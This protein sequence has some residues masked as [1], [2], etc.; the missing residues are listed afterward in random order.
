MAQQLT[1]EIADV[2]NAL[3]GK[4]AHFNLSVHDVPLDWFDDARNVKVWP[5]NKERG[6]YLSGDRTIDDYRLHL[7]SVELAARITEEPNPESIIPPAL[8]PVGH[9]DYPE[10]IG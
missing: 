3:I 7:Y 6:A 9:E 10:E 4:G 2:V 1:P 5:A 8:V